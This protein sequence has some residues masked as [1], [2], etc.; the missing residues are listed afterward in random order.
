M[1]GFLRP[2][3]IA[4]FDHWWIIAPAMLVLHFMKTAKG[5][6]DRPNPKNLHRVATRADN[7]SVHKAGL[8][9]GNGRE[10]HH[11]DTSRLNPPFFTVPAARSGRV[12]TQLC[13][14]AVFDLEF[15][16][17]FKRQPSGLYRPL[18]SRR[19]DD[20]ESFDTA[21]ETD[22]VLKFD[23]IDGAYMPCPWCGD[24]GNMRY[25]CDCGTVVCGG[26]VRGRKFHCR[27]S[28]GRSWVGQ[29]VHEFEVTEER[30]L[31][32]PHWRG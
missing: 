1:E 24:D 6:I 7:E 15:L 4:C 21:T 2:I 10:L 19:I 28:C 16:D 18:E 20:S 32:A 29:P 11:A 31:Q 27:S 8:L 25:Y 13:V 23:D 3:L 9:K 30:K 14:C 5:T 17:R 12:V 22:H 26:K